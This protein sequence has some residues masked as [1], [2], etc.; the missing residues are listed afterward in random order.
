MLAR[1]ALFAA[2]ALTL[3]LVGCSGGGSAGGGSPEAGG[4][5]DAPSHK[6][7]ASSDREPLPDAS[8]GDGGDAAPEAKARADSAPSVDSEGAGVGPCA[9]CTAGMCPTELEACAMSS[10]CTNGIVAFNSCFTA[11][12]LGTSCGATFATQ[13]SAAGAIWACMSTKCKSTCL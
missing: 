8:G 5:A 11:P 3:L 6:E 4:H 9:S 12:S 7:A 10:E 13:G 2:S 1:T